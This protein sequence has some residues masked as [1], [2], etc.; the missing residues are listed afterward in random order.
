MHLLRKNVAVNCCARTAATRSRIDCTI[1][2]SAGTGYEND[3]DVEQEHAT[4]S[5]AAGDIFRTERGTNRETLP[6]SPCVQ[7]LRW[8][9]SVHLAEALSIFGGFGPDVVLA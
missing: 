6:D 1:S 3:T 9:D 4:S 8:G 5:H 2:S 7:E